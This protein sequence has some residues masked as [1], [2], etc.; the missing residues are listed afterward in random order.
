MRLFEETTNQFSS[1][2]S[3]QFFEITNVN[4][5]VGL[6][7]N[8][9]SVQIG[10]LGN[11]E[12]KT[13]KELLPPDYKSIKLDKVK[14]NLF[15]LNANDLLGLVDYNNVLINPKYKNLKIDNINDDISFLKA[16]EYI[17]L[18]QH[19]K[20]INKIILQPDFDSIKLFKEDLFKVEKEGKSAIFSLS[21]GIT[22]LFDDIE[23]VY[24]NICIVCSNGK[25]GLLN[26]DKIVIPTKFESIIYLLSNYF[27]VYQN[28]HCGLF[29]LNKLLL[30]AK[31]NEI[32]VKPMDKNNFVVKADQ[33]YGF[34]TGSNWKPEITRTVFESKFCTKCASII[35]AFLPT[36]PACFSVNSE[37]SSIF[38]FI[39][40]SLSIFA[41]GIFR[42]SIGYFVF[43]PLLIVLIALLGLS[44]FHLL[45]KGKRSLTP[46]HI[47]ALNKPDSNKMQ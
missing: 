3:S 18:I 15:L 6:E 11:D 4:D 33:S 42:N 26:N 1:S 47:T 20:S 10:N 13:S 23:Y 35:P 39:L 34:V 2:Y 28:K 27:K 25:Y 9:I 46:L 19:N 43:L 24:S 38:L 22:T 37:N 17:G 32:N 5:R 41:Y 16:D 30:P 44:F 8:K 14:D 36:C 45:S 21:G 7:S 12:W 29:Y 40:F 31:Y